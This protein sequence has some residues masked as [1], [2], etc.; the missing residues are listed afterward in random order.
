MPCPILY[1]ASQTNHFSKTLVLKHAHGLAGPVARAA[2]DEIGCFPIQGAQPVGK[3]RVS[4]VQDQGR[5]GDAAHGEFPGR[6]DIQQDCVLTGKGLIEFG[7]RNMG[8]VI[9]LFRG[10]AAEMCRGHNQQDSKQEACR[11]SPLAGKTS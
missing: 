1:A 10:S 4:V 5:P 11:E 7:W 2:I 9:R 6:S 3:P 8:I